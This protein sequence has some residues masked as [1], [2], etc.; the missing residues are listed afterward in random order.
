M[1]GLLGYVSQTP[2]LAR[3]SSC[4]RD[5]STAYYNYITPHEIP[6]LDG[7]D[8]LLLHVSVGCQ[9]TNVWGS[10]WHEGRE[11]SRLLDS[12]TRQK[13]GLATALSRATIASPTIT[14][15]APRDA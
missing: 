7:S 5:C 9:G 12:R 8:T 13:T 14:R 15:S 2:G 10:M 3:V 11:R 1:I 4:L 6:T